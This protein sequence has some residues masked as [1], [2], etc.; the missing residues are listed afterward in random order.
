MQFTNKN[1]LKNEKITEKKKRKMKV[2]LWIV[3]KSHPL[4]ESLCKSR[5]VV[6]AAEIEVDD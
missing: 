4:L 3:Y 2:N 1:L 5:I 6:I